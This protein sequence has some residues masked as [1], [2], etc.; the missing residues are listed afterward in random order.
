M[1]W[2][3]VGSWSPQG[4]SDN[5]CSLPHLSDDSV[6]SD[7]VAPVTHMSKQIYTDIMSRRNIFHQA[8]DQ[9]KLDKSLFFRPIIPATKSARPDPHT[10]SK[11]LSTSTNLLQHLPNFPAKSIPHSNHCGFTHSNMCMQAYVCIFW[12]NCTVPL[13]SKSLSSWDPKHCPPGVQNILLHFN[14]CGLVHVVC[15]C[16]SIC[17][18]F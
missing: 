13:G 6:S 16:V 17:V 11:L 2:D 9:L 7:P 4:N 5:I 8:P 12:H 3:W 10:V 18:Y 1:R 15:E 14:H